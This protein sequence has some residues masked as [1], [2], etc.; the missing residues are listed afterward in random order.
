MTEAAL[1]SKL[2]ADALL[3]DSLNFLKNHGG[4]TFAL[5]K[6][7]YK[8]DFTPNKVL[9]TIQGRTKLLQEFQ[10]DNFM[11]IALLKNSGSVLLYAHKPE[12]NTSTELEQSLREW[13][14]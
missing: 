4:E 9:A 6:Y 10:Y 12:E 7:T 14:F 2:G 8:L 13:D 5:E 1:A 3:S 11:Q